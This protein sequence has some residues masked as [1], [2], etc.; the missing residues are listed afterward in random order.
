MK[1]FL[2][3][4]ISG[5]KELLQ[6]QNLVSVLKKLGIVIVTNLDL[7]HGEFDGSGFA[8]ID[9]VIIDATAT[10]VDTGYTLAIALAHKKPVLYLLRKGTLLDSSVDALASNKEVQK[11]LHVQFYEPDMIIRKVKNF[12]QYLDHSIGKESFSIKYT[13]RLSPRI[14]RYLTWKSAEAKKNKADF[15][16]DWVEGL[17]KSDDHYTKRLD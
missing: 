7:K 6:H 17:M 15:L 11:L 9:A 16:R 4:S 10:D 14:D 8:S 5:P 2:S 3:T 13:L 1:L 12:L